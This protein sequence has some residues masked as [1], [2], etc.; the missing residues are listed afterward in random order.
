[1]QYTCVYVLQ[2]RSVKHQPLYQTHFLYLRHQ[3]FPC[4]TRKRKKIWRVWGNDSKLSEAKSYLLMYWEWVTPD[5][6]GNIEQDQCKGIDL[7]CGDEHLQLFWGEES[8]V[9]N[10]ATRVM[11][12]WLP[13]ICSFLML[14]TGE[15]TVSSTPIIIAGLGYSNFFHV[16]WDCMQKEIS[17]NW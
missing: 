6:T 7:F 5:N 1:M 2:V 14:S 4:L 9:Q 8:A 17:I 10:E 11:E 13:N 15:N 3:M 16:S 12:K